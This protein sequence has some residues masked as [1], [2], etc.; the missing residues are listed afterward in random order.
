MR[1]AIAIM[2]G[3]ESRRMGR[4]KALLHF[5]GEPMLAR[6]TRLAMRTGGDVV[7][8][9]R[10]RPAEWRGEDELPGFCRTSSPGTDRSAGLSLHS[11][12]AA[13]R[14]FRSPA[15]FLC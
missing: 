9:G 6:A 1:V 14:C 3:G 4:D 7:V 8:I 5:R 10:E 12:I 11:G 2:A 13:A 15:I